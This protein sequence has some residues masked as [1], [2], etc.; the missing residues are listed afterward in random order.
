MILYKL[1][2]INS[3]YSKF[4][5]IN[6]D[7]SLEIPNSEKE[8]LFENNP[9]I[10]HSLFHNDIV[11]L[12]NENDSEIKIKLIKRES[13]PIIIGEL[14]IYSPYILKTN[15]NTTYYIFQ[16]LDKHYPKFSVGFANKT[17]YSSNI[18]ISINNL[19][20]EYNDV[21]PSGNLL[22]LIGETRL[23]DSTIETLLRFN[24]LIFKPTYINSKEVSEKITYLTQ[25][26]SR[27]LI[28]SPI[29]SI[30]PEGCR[31]IDDAFSIIDNQ[32][33]MQV[34]IHISDVYTLLRA[35]D[36]QKIINIISS[37][38]LPTKVIPMIPDILSSNYASLLQNENRIMITL[39]FN[40][41]KNTG[42][43]D[44]KHYPS[45]GRI[46][47]N[48]S[49]ENTD[50]KFNKYFPCIAG[51]YRNYIG[52]PF[53]IT[54]TH[55]FIEC[56]ML[57]YNFMFGNKIL[58]NYKDTIYRCQKTNIDFKPYDIDDLILKRFLDIQQSESAEYLSNIE[59]N[60]HDSLKMHNYL[61]MTSPIRRF[62][63]LINQCIYYNHCKKGIDF[64]DLDFI[65]NQ[66][67]LIKK[68]SRQANKLFLA[69][70][71]YNTQSY[72]TICYVYK[73]NIDKNKMSLY[74]PNEKLS[75]SIKIVP[76]KI[77]S[78]TSIKI[79]NN[80]LNIQNSILNQTIPLFKE[81]SVQING[82]PNIYYI[83]DSISV[84]FY[85]CYNK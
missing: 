78:L 28:T 41:D 54:D 23:I 52:K 49:Y 24:N 12:D 31:D 72:Y 42:E 9:K 71:A 16:P 48:Y 63:D 79:D 74:F 43:I 76:D 67:K 27:K 61:H 45:V 13:N 85:E 6:I 5:L 15:K 38:Y 29:Y 60:Y 2:I 53:N 25:D 83:D 40:I 47:K 34:L 46:T 84:D 57:I 10:I 22:H 77:I 8:L 59:N 65:N 4:S 82:N 20:W 21:L 39:E 56:M 58:N 81:L 55:N 70:F 75:F 26:K 33:N 3:D 62:A 73:V 18:F 1:N 36:K 44:F 66:S 11:K 17:K 68:V 69:D 80:Y 50:N 37:I 14:Q 30:D 51:I 64:I 35:L 7:D 32:N 19:T